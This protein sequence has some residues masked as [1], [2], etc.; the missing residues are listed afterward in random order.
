MKVCYSILVVILGMLAWVQ[1]QAEVIHRQFSEHSLLV[2]VTDDSWQPENFENGIPIPAA[3]LNQEEIT[4]PLSHGSTN[5]A[6]V[7]AL[8][9]NDDVLIRVRWRDTS[10]NRLHHPWHWNEGFNTL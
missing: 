8:Y 6:K 1:V 2:K 10:E 5:Q 3:Y 7:K 9:T 4:V